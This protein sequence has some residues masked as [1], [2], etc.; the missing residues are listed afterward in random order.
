M[1]S[2]LLFLSLFFVSMAFA[3]PKEPKVYELRIYHCEPG[4]LDALLARFR[5]YTTGLFEKHGMKNVGYW[6]PTVEGSNDLYYILEYP[7]M[8]AREASWKAFMDDPKWKEV[9]AESEKTGK[10]VAKIESIFMHMHPELTKKL[11]YKSKEDNEMLFEYRR[12]YLLPERYPNIVARFKDHT[13]K[14]IEKQGMKN[15]VYFETH[16]KEGVQPT[17]LYF[18]VHKNAASAKASWDNFGESE[19]WKKIRDASEVDGKI[20]EKVEAV[21][22]KGTDFSK[23]K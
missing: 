23:I 8:A 16:E 11:K 7:N 17:L 22:M 2:L 13:R 19:E 15:L 10:I 14:L 20:V 5:N 9:W 3:K 21:Y 1:K 4:R 6:V 18:L 12:Y